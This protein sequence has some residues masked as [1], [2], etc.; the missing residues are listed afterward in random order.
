MVCVC[1]CMC[2]CVCLKTPKCG[3]ACICCFAGFA[4]GARTLAMEYAFKSMGWHVGSP[5]PGSPTPRAKFIFV[6]R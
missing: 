4:L 1:V 6:H 2:L 3:A 5:E